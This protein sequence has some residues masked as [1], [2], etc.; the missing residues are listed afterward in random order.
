MDARVCAGLVDGRCAV[1][2]WP[3]DRCWPQMRARLVLAFDS[4]TAALTNPPTQHPQPFA[5]APATCSGWAPTYC[6]DAQRTGPYCGATTPPGAFRIN[7]LFAAD[8]NGNSRAGCEWGQGLTGGLLV[9]LGQKV[10]LLA[11]LGR[12]P[13]WVHPHLR[14]PAACAACFCLALDCHRALQAP[15]PPL[16]RPSSRKTCCPSCAARGAAMQV[17]RGR[18]QAVELSMHSVAGPAA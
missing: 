16:T 9:R 13:L 15:A 14:M 12:L 1:L 5:A 8:G 18:G 17:C 4:L 10:W 11:G 3:C 2:I 7:R 6:Y